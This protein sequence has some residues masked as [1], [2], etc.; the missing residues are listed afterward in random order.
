MKAS[1]LVV[2]DEPGI[3]RLCQRL[4][5]KA[6][7]KVTAVQNSNEAVSSLQEIK[8]DVVLADIRM[9]GLSG[10]QLMELARQHQPEL[11]IVLMTGYGTIETAIEALQRGADGLILKPFAGSELVQGV[12]IALQACMHKRDSLRLRLLRPLFE[13]IKHFFAITEQDELIGQIINA[14]TNHLARVAAR[15]GLCRRSA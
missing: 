9:P 4:L 14:V 6:G 2:D 8:F 15:T 10:F 12:E 3:L 1:V 11:A 7:A 13:T 5:G